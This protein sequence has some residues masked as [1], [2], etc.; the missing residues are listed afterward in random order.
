ME[1]NSHLS[2]LLAALGQLPSEQPWQRFL[3]SPVTC[4]RM[5]TGGLSVGKPW[6]AHPEKDR[7][8]A[9]STRTHH[10]STERVFKGIRTR[11]IQTLAKKHKDSARA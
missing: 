6:Q 5:L 9:L 11:E 1:T 2:S 7:G 3:Q 4:T 8:T 10:N